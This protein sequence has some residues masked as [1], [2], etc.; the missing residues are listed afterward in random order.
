MK[1][2]IR[3]GY[4]GLISLQRPM[5]RTVYLS[6]SPEPLDTYTLCSS[7]SLTCCLP[8]VSHLDCLFLKTDDVYLIKIKT[9][10]S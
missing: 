5:V 8:I 10:P 9:V 2:Q 3:V 4:M 6:Q 7:P 1:T